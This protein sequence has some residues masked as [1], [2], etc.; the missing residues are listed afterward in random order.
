MVHLVPDEGV[1]DGPVLA[2]QQVPILSDDTRATLE[3]RI[4]AVEHELF[5]A[6]IADYLRTR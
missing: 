4:H 6:T 1:D 2:S 3:E 5:V